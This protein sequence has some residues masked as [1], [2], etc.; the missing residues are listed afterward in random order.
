MVN[1]FDGRSFPCT[2]FMPPYPDASGTN[3]ICTVVGSRP[4]E[5]FVRGAEYLAIKYNY[6]PGHLWRNCG[7]LIGFILFFTFTYLVAVEFISAAKSK[8]EVLVFKDGY[9]PPSMKKSDG[10]IEG[11]TK[12]DREVIRTMADVQAEKSKLKDALHSINYADKDIF[13]WRDVCYDIK[14]K[15]EDR[16][17]LDHVDGWYVRLLSLCSPVLI[18]RF[19]GSC[20]VLLLRSWVSPAPA[21]RLFWTFWLVVS[22]WE[23]FP[24]TCS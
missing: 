12:G 4:G 15:K 17:L 13:M 16:R 8:G 9:V 18:S 19:L 14:I 21:R 20:P 10:D 24:V 2:T 11:H 7:I 22:P 3:R 23:S 5:N 6:L 1:E